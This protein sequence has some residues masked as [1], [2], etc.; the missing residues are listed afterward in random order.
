MPGTIHV[1]I[2][3]HPK[4][5]GRTVEIRRTKA[6]TRNAFH[7]KVQLVQPVLLRGGTQLQNEARKRLRKLFVW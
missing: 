2:P 3:S 7:F 1:D 4:Q 5:L 6:L